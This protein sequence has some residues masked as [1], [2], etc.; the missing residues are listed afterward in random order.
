M[1]IEGL[2]LDPPKTSFLEKTKRKILSSYRSI[3]LS[4]SL[5][6]AS[7]RLHVSSVG[8][9]SAVASDTYKHGA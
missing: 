6:S 5:S 7:N 3:V 2:P 4:R 8:V 9:A 1:Y